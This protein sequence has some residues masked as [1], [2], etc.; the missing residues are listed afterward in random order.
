MAEKFV[1]PDELKDKG[2]LI[3]GPGP[4]RVHP[5]R[6]NSESRAETFS[7]ISGIF[8]NRSSDDERIKNIQRA[9]SSSAPKKL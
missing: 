8:C 6:Q 5:T 4:M 1:I 3:G 2:N 9:K 7:I